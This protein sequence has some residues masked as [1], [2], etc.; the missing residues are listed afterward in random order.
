MSTER[1]LNDYELSRP[2]IVLAQRFVQRWDL[3]A[4]QLADGRYICMHETLNVGHLFAHLRGEITLGLYCLNQKNKARFIVLDAD[5]EVS[6]KSLLQINSS[7]I[8]DHIPSYL[9]TSRRGGHLWLFFENAVSGQTA[10]NFGLSILAK[11]NSEGV[12]LFPKQDHLSHGPGSLIRCPFGI[13]RMTGTRY[14]FIAPNG[15]PLAP[16]IREQ[17]YMLSSPQTVPEAIIKAYPTHSPSSELSILPER[18]SEPSAMLSEK[19]KSSITVLEFISQYVDLKPTGSGAIGLCPFHDDQH[20]SLGI[21]D[22]KNYWHCFA[23]CGGGSIIDFWMKWKK[24]D[25]ITAVTELENI[26]L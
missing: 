21:N 2:A 1:L 12:E 13:H 22:K 3:Y 19:I 23:S 7:L 15:T 18:N 5:D 24:C 25:F 9:E 14:G 20:P 10:R 4:R 6:Y 11:H 8:S 16:T 26:L 17:I